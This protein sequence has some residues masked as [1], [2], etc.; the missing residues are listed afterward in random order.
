MAIWAMTRFRDVGDYTLLGGSG[1]DILSGGLGNDVL[2]GFDLNTSALGGMTS[3][4]GADQVFGGEGNDS[5]L[6]GHGDVAAGG[7]GEDSFV[8]DHRF[9]D[10]ALGYRITDYT[11]GSDQIEVTP[12]ALM[13]PPA[14][15]SRPTFRWNC[16][17]MAKAR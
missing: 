11:A 15:R 16:R 12:P 5:L 10:A 8:L 14:P 7:A 17:R 4:D 13:R 1:N 9:N 2:S 6:L 3:A